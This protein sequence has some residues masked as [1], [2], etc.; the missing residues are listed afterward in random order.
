MAHSPE[1]L[2][3]PVARLP[4][5]PAG[6]AP[7]SAITRDEVAHLARLARLAVTEEELDLFAGQLDA[8]LADVKRVNEVA[9]DDIPPMSHAVTM[10]NVLRPDVV[11]PS[12]PRQAALAAAPA[13]EQDRFRVPRIL[14]EE[15]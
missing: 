7:P 6:S 9:A 4:A 14:N 15:E 5:M 1:G 2:Q 3:S 11:R 13:T 10:S 8:I 12:L